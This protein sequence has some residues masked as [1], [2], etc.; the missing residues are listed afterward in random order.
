MYIYVHIYM[1]M[2]FTC[3]HI[4]CRS[5]CR[6]ARRR[7]PKRRGPNAMINERCAGIVCLCIAFSKCVYNSTLDQ[8]CL[9][10]CFI[11]I[12]VHKAHTHI[13]TRQRQ[14]VWKFYGLHG[15]GTRHTSFK[16]KSL[17]HVCV[18][19]AGRERDEMLNMLHRC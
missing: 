19:M 3:A 1:Y 11:Y 15:N 9:C 16:H 2:H 17:G 12:F 10:S 14:I 18:M 8:K 7:P 13:H 6:E 5:A 4:L